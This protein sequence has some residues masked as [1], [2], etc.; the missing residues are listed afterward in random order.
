MYN[1]NTK[2]TFITLFLVLVAFTANAFTSG[3][4]RYE[5]VPS[6]GLLG[7]LEQREA[8]VHSATQEITGFLD[9]P[10]NVSRSLT[11]WKITSI[12]E[13]ALQN[14]KLTGLE[15]SPAIRTI[16]KYAF[17][18]CPNLKSVSTKRGLK[19]I[20]SNAFSECR[21]LETFIFPESLKLIGEHAFRNCESLQ[22]VE[23]YDEL[24]SIREWAF[25]GCK[26]LSSVSIKSPIIE[27]SAGCFSFCSSLKEITLPRSVRTIRQSA[28]E[29]SGLEVVRM[30]KFVSKIE[31]L[32]F[33]STN[34]HTIYLQA[35]VPPEASFIVMNGCPER[36]TLHV[37]SSSK[38]A[39]KSHPYWGQFIVVGD[40]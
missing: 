11:N 5:K 37:P 9:I 27:I 33:A 10:Y 8:I 7:L 2:S 38:D 14:C 32:A 13:Y 20:E 35:P 28:F 31:N 36:I 18:N 1:I 16:G 24:T 40:L 39:Y 4:I 6:E 22:S 25:Y 23:L 21:N 29:Y 34:L 26:S 17:N 12:R 15:L 19:F 3:P 30:D